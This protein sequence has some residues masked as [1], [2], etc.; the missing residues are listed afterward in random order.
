M[1]QK[2]RVFR[3]ILPILNVALAG[4]LFRVG[5][6]E[7]RRI[8]AHGMF[9]PL[10]DSVEKARYV[11]YTLNAPAWAA[12]SVMPWILHVNE[13]VT[14]WKMLETEGDWW[15]MLFVFVMWYLI[16]RRIDTWSSAATSESRTSALWVKG[17]RVALIAYGGFIWYRL[18]V[19]PWRLDYW[20][21]AAVLA[22]GAALIIGN[23]YLLIRRPSSARD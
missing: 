9:E 12:Q 6:A 1:R 14:Y 19:T 4:L 20:F 18:P 2:K 17:R 8:A 21:I 13:R 11:S 7:F 22:W 23:L 5:Y 15:Y 16:G 10:P 3:I